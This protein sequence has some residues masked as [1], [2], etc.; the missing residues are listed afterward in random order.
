MKQEKIVVY[1]CPA[2]SVAD[3]AR[4]QL[5]AAATVLHHQAADAHAQG[6]SLEGQSIRIEQ[7]AILLNDEEVLKMRN[8]FVEE[9]VL[10]IET[11]VGVDVNSQGGDA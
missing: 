11:Q 1:T 7:L 2:E 8:L 10:E 4:L 9:G 3:E 5:R 6:M